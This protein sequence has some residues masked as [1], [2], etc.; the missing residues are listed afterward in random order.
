MVQ[1]ELK[2]FGEMSMGDLSSAVM[3]SSGCSKDHAKRV[4]RAM[5][6]DDDALTHRRDGSKD[7]YSIK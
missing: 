6:R 1:V 4:I 2:R 7:L 3:Q 5:L